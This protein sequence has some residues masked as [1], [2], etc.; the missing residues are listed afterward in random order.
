M[1]I[2]MVN[3]PQEP[4]SLEIIR[5]I[6]SDSFSARDHLLNIF[7]AALSAAPFFG[8]ISSLMNDYIP[9][10]RAG[11]MEG[12]AAQVAEDLRQLQDKVRS[13]YILTDDFAFLFE[14]CFRA[15]AETPQKEK[16][17]ALRAVLVN[18]T[19]STDLKEEEKEFFLSLAMNLSTL[20]LR[21][22]RFMATPEEYLK[23]A[24][25]PPQKITGGFA[26]FFPVAMPGIHLDV[27]KSAFADLYQYGLSSTDRG[28][29]GT[30]TAGR[31]L[32]LLKG[33]VSAL[34]QSFISFCTIRSQQ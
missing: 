8:A 13:E 3:L 2:I 19:V 11:R 15:V 28:I 23:A 26:E 33:R 10:S 17:Q 14:K 24:N 22:L 30:I 21:I 5:R 1:D 12:F 9:S 4:K 29:F 34:G 32:E 6:Q 31:G 16:L 27:I 25:I 18:S 20:H 7:K